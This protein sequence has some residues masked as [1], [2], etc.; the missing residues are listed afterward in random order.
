MV[1]A[2]EKTAAN[3]SGEGVDENGLTEAERR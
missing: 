1:A 2:R 3:S